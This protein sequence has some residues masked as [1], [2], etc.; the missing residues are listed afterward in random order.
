MQN[1]EWERV[2]R[3]LHSS[4]CILHFSLPCLQDVLTA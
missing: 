2:T 1:E 3:F 4:F